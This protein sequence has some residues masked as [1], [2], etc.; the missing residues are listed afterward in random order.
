MVYSIM[1]SDT[2]KVSE[3]VGIANKFRGPIRIIS[4]KYRVNAKSIMGMLTL[5]LT[6]KLTVEIEDAEAE[7]FGEE[8]ENFL[9][10]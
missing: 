4:D 2:R 9:V 7:A 8:I 1:L 5:D 6:K 3:F 10:K